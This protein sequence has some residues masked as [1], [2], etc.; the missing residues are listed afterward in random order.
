MSESVNKNIFS[1]FLS[2]VDG[3]KAINDELFKFIDEIKAQADDNK[4]ELNAIKK[5]SLDYDYIKSYNDLIESNSNVEITSHYVNILFDALDSLKEST[6]KSY[7]ATKNEEPN[8][9]REALNELYKKLVNELLLIT[10]ILSY[11]FDRFSIL[12]NEL[13]RI[14]V[15][16]GY[17]GNEELLGVYLTTFQ[18]NK[19]LDNFYQYLI[20]S[21][22]CIG[23]VSKNYLGEWKKID[24]VKVLL[25]FLSKTKHINQNEIY[26]CMALAFCLTDEE[27][28]NL[29]EIGS[30][31][32]EIT[33]LIGQ[34]SNEIK[35]GEGLVRDELELESKEK[36]LVCCTSRN[37]ASLW[38]LINLLNAIYAL[39]IN[40]QTKDDI[41]FEHNLKD[42]LKNIIEFGNE[43]EISYSLYVLSQLSFDAKVA[44]DIL[45]DNQYNDLIND[46]LSKFEGK[47]I[48]TSQKFIVSNS[49]SI[50]WNLTN[51][52]KKE[53][54]TIPP[55]K[56]LKE[57]ISFSVPNLVTRYIMISYN[58]GS[59]ELC[60]K[61]KGELE[62]LGYK[63]W[64]DV[65]QISGS[66]LEAMANALENSF[67]VLM[68]M[69]EK[70]KQSV[71]CRAEAEYAFTLNKPI[72]PLIMQKDYKPDGWLGKFFFSSFF[73]IYE[74][75][76]SKV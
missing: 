35:T 58:T 23:R 75:K 21:L 68:C 14:K 36:V 17:L 69:T 44:E 40:D 11:T 55:I 54:K 7:T 20:G 45:N 16:I 38:N 37:G 15:L 65:E 26:T 59:R 8:E 25:N 18:E 19:T 10:N 22:V 60:L 48:T 5:I 74:S 63:I 70:Y 51:K 13:K 76:H 41:Y 64:I 29:P 72:I 3:R 2:G 56:S 53:K 4:D 46:L 9:L 42:Y 50:K 34:A 49:K 66:S 1:L 43:I 6:V 71:N 28:G 27:I 33:K 39:A 24:A 61:I 30:I 32:P 12:A 57:V 52:N 62:K 73:D 67:C 47:D 31:I